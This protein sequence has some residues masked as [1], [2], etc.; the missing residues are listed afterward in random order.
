[1]RLLG[2]LEEDKWEEKSQRKYSW[3]I[4]EYEHRKLGRL[5]HGSASI[6]DDGGVSP[7]REQ[8]LSEPSCGSVTL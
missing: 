2:I 1:M 6:S 5:L 4:I 7:Y 3:G 8:G